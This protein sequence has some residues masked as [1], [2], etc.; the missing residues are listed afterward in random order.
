MTGLRTRENET[1]ETVESD[2][3]RKTGFE[4]DSEGFQVHQL[5]TWDG[6]EEDTDWEMPPTVLCASH[7]HIHHT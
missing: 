6:Q 1:N 7:R 2:F 4:P 3:R 5:A